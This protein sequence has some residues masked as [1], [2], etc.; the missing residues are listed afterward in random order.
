[1]RSH[2]GFRLKRHTRPIVPALTVPVLALALGCGVRVRTAN[3]LSAIRVPSRVL[4][5]GDSITLGV[6]GELDEGRAQTQRSYADELSANFKEVIN[7]GQGAERL[8]RVETVRRFS[9]VLSRYRC[10]VAIVMEGSLD[11]IAFA[12]GGWRAIDELE[13]SLQQV[14]EISRSR[15]VRLVLATVP[16]QILKTHCLSVCRGAGLEGTAAV[17]R[18]IRRIALREKLLLVDVNA[19]FRRD[20]YLVNVDGLHLTEEGQHRVAQAMLRALTSAE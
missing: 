10:D 14:V 6:T 17:N 9:D 12:S 15:G 2:D 16:P 20:D 5:F 19:A 4:V 7:V 13:R 8:G 1:M 18:A 3:S 11:A